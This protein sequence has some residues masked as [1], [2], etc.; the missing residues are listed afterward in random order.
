MFKYI[1]NHSALIKEE[2]EVGGGGEDEGD[3]TSFKGLGRIHILAW[4]QVLVKDRF[5]V[6]GV[7]FLLHLVTYLEIALGL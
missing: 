4:T 3:I 6:L 2:E 7:T 1:N 5:K